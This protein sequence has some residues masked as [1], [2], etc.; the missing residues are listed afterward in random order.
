[1]IE[2]V[3]LVIVCFTE[4]FYL[5]DIAFVDFML[6]GFVISIGPK[7]VRVCSHLYVRSVLVFRCKYRMYAMMEDAYTFRDQSLFPI[8]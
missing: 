3:R 7:N 1:M 4:I 5:A 2:L 8:V 6:P